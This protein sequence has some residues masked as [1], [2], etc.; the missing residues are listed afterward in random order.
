VPGQSQVLNDVQRNTATGEVTFIF[1]D[2]NS[3]SFPS[4]ELAKQELQV[5][6]SSPELAQK[7]LMYK[8][9][10]NSPD[11]TNMTTMNGVNCSVNFNASVPIA[12]IEP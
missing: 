4:W 1:A 10:T 7:I 2:G 6:D 8:A 12:L 5:L 3:I 9:V 11:G